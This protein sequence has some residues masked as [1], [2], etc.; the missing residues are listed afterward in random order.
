MPPDSLELRERKCRYVWAVEEARRANVRLEASPQRQLLQGLLA[1]DAW[2]AIGLSG[3]DVFKLCYTIRPDPKSRPQ[4]FDLTVRY[5][6]NTMFSIHWETDGGDLD[7]LSHF[8]GHAA[9][10]TPDE[11]AF[12]RGLAEKTYGAGR[13]VRGTL[14]GRSA[15][16]TS[17]FFGYIEAV[18]DPPSFGACSRSFSRHFKD[19][20]PLDVRFWQR[21]LRSRALDTQ[22]GIGLLP[23][24]ASK[25]MEGYVPLPDPL[26]P[27][28][29]SGRFDPP[30][31][32]H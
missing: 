25:G 10:P 30:F 16:V 22:I 32:M 31:L 1:D 9:W 4:E 23:S 8:S 27:G 7:A 15:W 12:A 21:Y 17:G 6:P 14:G 5:P 26:N 24:G 2:E 3:G 28:R 13:I 11:A 29:P 20:H 19:V 18:Y